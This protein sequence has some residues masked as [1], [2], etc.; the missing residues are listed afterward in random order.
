MQELE[1]E[2]LRHVFAMVLGVGVLVR[3]MGCVQNHVL[4]RVCMIDL[5]VR[6]FPGNSMAS[7]GILL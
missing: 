6:V 2:D 1:F 5:L 7:I 4:V 3:S